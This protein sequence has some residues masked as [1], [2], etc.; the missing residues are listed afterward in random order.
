MKS[1]G[2]TKKPHEKMD[3]TVLAMENGPFIDGIY[4]YISGWWFQPTPLRNISSSVGIMTFPY[5][6]K[7]KWKNK[8]N[9]PNHQT[10]RD[11]YSSNISG[12]WF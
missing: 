9:V 5:I 8:I 12:W 10:E 3:F 4:I 7:Q 2:E 6:S 1:R 11:F